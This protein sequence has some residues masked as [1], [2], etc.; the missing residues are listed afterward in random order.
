MQVRLVLLALVLVPALAGC[1]APPEDAERL[2]RGLLD[3]LLG[4]GWKEPADA[5]IR[6]GVPLR[7]EVGECATNFV[8][9]RVDNGSVFLGSTAYCARDLPVG[10]LATVGAGEHRAILVYSSYATMDEVG[11]ADP[12]AREYNDFA[13]WYIDSAARGEVSPALLDVGGPVGLADAEQILA[14]DRL[15]AYTAPVAEAAGWRSAAVTGRVEHWALLAHGAPPA[16]PGGMGGGVITPDGEAVGILVNLGAQPGGGANGVA[17][18]DAV[19]AYAAEHANL[20]MLLATWAYD[21]APVA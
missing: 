10:A 11:E 19:M 8:F 12:A 20:D 21:G 18:L 14:G 9:T 16:L 13:V 15:L 5:L 17:R 7:T 1:A 3:E 6:P 4:S 2:D